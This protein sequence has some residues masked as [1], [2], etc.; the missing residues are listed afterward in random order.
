MGKRYVVTY[1]LVSETNI[2]NFAPEMTVHD[3]EEADTLLIF[4]CHDIAREDPFTECIVLSPDTDVFL[5]LIHHYPSLT[6]S[7]IFRTGRGDNIRDISIRSCYESI[8]TSRAK[9]L[10][11]FHTLTGC[12]QTGRFHG[13]SKV[14]WWKE[15]CETENNI[16]EAIS[17]LGM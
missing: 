14:F 4:H 16:V 8:G 10:L 11:G 2:P 13:K 9:A 3:H 12:D 17:E 1:D 6:Q 7:V 15:F 5:L